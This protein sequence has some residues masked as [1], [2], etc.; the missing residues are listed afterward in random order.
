MLNFRKK[1]VNFVSVLFTIC[2][3]VGICSTVYAS[4]PSNI[5][6]VDFEFLMLQHPDMASAQETIK[7]EAEQSQK[8]FD[9]KVASMTNDQDKKIYFSQLQQ[10]LDEKK[11]TLIT[12][13]QD[14]VIAVVKN[15]ADTKG[16]AVVVDKSNAVYGGQDITTEVGN[17][18]F[19]K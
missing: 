3:V 15:V 16:L 8:D 9:N 12:K 6:I 14:K 1:Y 5:G 7:N 4:P 2:F 17:K 18:I 19:S 11:R 13:I 10:Q